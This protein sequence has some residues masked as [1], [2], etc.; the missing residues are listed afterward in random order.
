MIMLYSCS[1]CEKKFSN[2]QSLGGHIGS[3]SRKG[4]KV[5]KYTKNKTYICPYCNK[6][7]YNDKKRTYC[8]RECFGKMHSIRWVKKRASKTIYNFPEKK[9]I[10][11]KSNHSNCEICGKKESVLNRSLSIDHDHETGDFRGILCFNCNVRL[12]WFIENKNN[13]VLYINRDAPIV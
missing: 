5:G 1:K 4:K 13:I 11:Y 2:S 3:H 10:E 9:V 6:K 7:F 8:S 12:E